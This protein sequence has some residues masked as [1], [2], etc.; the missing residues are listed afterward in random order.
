MAES[1]SA[2]VKR[3]RS[4]RRKAEQKAKDD[5][6][7]FLSGLNLGITNLPEMVTSIFPAATALVG[8]NDDIS[9]GDAWKGLGTGVLKGLVDTGKTLTDA[10]GVPMIVEG[11][12]GFSP[13]AD[14]IE[15]ISGYKPQS[16][17][18]KLFDPESEGLVPGL[19]NDVGNVAILAGGAGAVAKAG[20]AG[21]VANLANKAKVAGFI[22]D[23][24]RLTQVGEAFQ[25]AARTGGKMDNI[26]TAAKDI[27]KVRRAM[28]KVGKSGAMDDPTDFAKAFAE[29]SGARRTT[30]DVL[31]K[32]AHPYISMRDSVA[33]PLAQAMSNEYIKTSG[34]VD[35][36]ADAARVTEKVADDLD[37][38][39]SIID[40][41]DDVTAAK[42]VDDAAKN[43][44]DDA[45][46]GGADLVG[47]HV[48]PMAK[49]AMRE[50]TDTAKWAES[51]AAASPRS[52]VRAG[53][54]VNRFL[55]ARLTNAS[56]REA[57]LLVEAAKRNIQRTPVMRA[58][59]KIV[60]AIVGD[61]TPHKSGKVITRGEASE[62]VA[63]AIT[64]RVQGRAGLQDMFSG[65]NQALQDAIGAE[66]FGMSH[67]IPE[68][69]LTP[70]LSA[71][72][73]EAAGMWSAMTPEFKKALSASPLTNEGFD[74][75][76]GGTST[77]SQSKMEAL[78]RVS[79]RLERLIESGDVTTDEAASVLQR[80]RDV[81]SV[82][83]GVDDVKSI[84]DNWM[85][86]DS[87]TNR[88]RWARAGR[89]RE[90]ER[91]ATEQYT[92]AVNKID[93]DLAAIDSLAAKAEEAI[94]ESVG[95]KQRSLK[96]VTRARES[97]QAKANR[98][99]DLS[100]RAAKQ[101]QDAEAI[102]VM[103]SRKAANKPQLPG[104]VW[105][106]QDDMRKIERLRQRA[107]ENRLE[108]EVIRRGMPAEEADEFVIKS[109]TTDAME[110]LARRKA[111]LAAKRAR[112]QARRAQ[113]D[114][115]LAAVVNR[116]DDI[117]WP[118]TVELKDKRGT[119]GHKSYRQQALRRAEADATRDMENDVSAIAEA[120]RNPERTHI[121][122]KYRPAHE[123][124][125]NI[126]TAMDEL[127][128]EALNNP[129]LAGI[130]D[131][132][133]EGFDLFLQ[134]LEDA[135]LTPEFMPSL[136]A[137]Q[138]E[139]L[140][141]KSVR[142]SDSLR[143]TR[144]PVRTG[145]RATSWSEKE[146]LDS[147]QA[148]HISVVKE[149]QDNA[150]IDVLNSRKYALPEGV[151]EP[152]RNYTRWSPTE[153]KLPAS[154]PPDA[155]GVRYVVSENDLKVLANRGKEINVGV[156]NTIA[157][158]TTNPWRLLM[159]TLSP[160]YYI[161][162][163]SMA[164]AVVAN[165]G[166][167]N[168]LTIA[169]DASE[170]FKLFKKISREGIDPNNLD[171]VAL[172]SLSGNNM[173]SPDPGVPGSVMDDRVFGKVRGVPV[174][175]RVRGAVMGK[176]SPVAK[177]HRLSKAEARAAG[178]S[179]AIG[180]L[181]QGPPSLVQ[182]RF[183]RANEA[184]D[185]FYR[186][187][188][189]ISQ[190]R[191]GANSTEALSLAQKN[192][193]DYGDLSPFE[194]GVVRKIIPFYA[195][196]KGILKVV[197]RYTGNHPIVTSLMLSLGEMAKEYMEDNDIPPA[198]FGILNIPGTDIMINTRQWNPF[199]DAPAIMTPE[200]A[201]QGFGP[202][203]EAVSR[204]A[205]HAPEGGYTRNYRTDAI[206]R[207]VA[208]VSAAEGLLGS[209]TSAP[210]LQIP[211]TA[212]QGPDYEGQADTGTQFLRFLGAPIVT[213]GQLQ[214]GKDRIAAAKARNKDIPK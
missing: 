139:N 104:L 17:I 82:K 90:I 25:T 87:P 43:I 49:K 167:L 176:K 181:T 154:A 191:Q 85:A 109:L 101:E 112:L 203:A 15:S 147:L 184:V 4:A 65:E 208:D 131:G 198:Y 171:E 151:T 53:D 135:G 97:R 69:L 28:T 159:L 117:A 46:R 61:G 162:N 91:D 10:T 192:L 173:F 39:E 100:R 196:Q 18:D 118:E 108:A 79:E 136:T 143:Y 40:A 140:V 103:A 51:V 124:A 153:G 207:S 73:D 175:E 86:G 71:A 174:E 3:R 160:K 52:V 35:D 96:G 137:K 99:A 163:L 158:F 185:E 165:S 152:P 42:I 19:I 63:E 107:L 13:T 146:N 170:A 201:F 195:W 113:L 68:E 38:A 78:D 133:S 141:H 83:D 5:G 41:V 47:D 128:I 80:L 134:K 59:K 130:V 110:K 48:G 122:Q 72:I 56:A 209:F 84:L 16:A 37:Q 66:G 193:V 115:D 187:W 119:A 186:M 31:D 168:P 98:I 92:R 2:Q 105:H 213:E 93:D 88:V 116:E 9:A 127:G 144:S 149:L 57:E 8:M 190:K 169:K 179:E 194:R 132:V 20:S 11:T 22:D 21:K 67:P 155:D 94:V 150:M 58:T 205:L 183:T 120:L 142:S 126:K 70:E 172:A 166:T 200:G 148:A 62:M 199:A 204:Q 157:K 34:I 44:A 36:I 114:Q 177:A 197:G 102:A 145:E 55:N 202:F 1:L 64:A 74:L 95:P 129:Q 214:R 189:Y 14:L 77:L 33:K 30:I 188:E 50:G 54:A 7:N 60:D 111:R 23:A 24:G 26:T 75:M 27:S 156:L 121:P 138:V 161:N 178:R 211:R 81:S 29:S 12:T 206:G 89:A 212:T 76:D 32:A 182:R 125:T 106:S 164:L 180:W 210:Q 123:I 6:G 45:A